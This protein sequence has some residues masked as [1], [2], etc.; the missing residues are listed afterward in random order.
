M[1]QK[2][3][4]FLGILI[5]VAACSPN[6]VKSDKAIDNLFEKAALQ[7]SFALLENGTEQFTIHNLSRYRDSAY[8]PLNS[9]FILPALIGFDKGLINQHPDSWKAFDAA[10]AYTSLIQKIGRQE[11]LKTIDSLHYGKGIVSNNMD[12][13][14]LDNSLVITA[15]EQL[16]LIKKLY[17]NEL[18][19]NKR[20]QDLAKKLIIKEDNANYKLSYILGAANA[21]KNTAWLIGYVEENKHPYFFVLNTEGVATQNVAKQ[22]EQLLK[23]ILLQQGFLKGTR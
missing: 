21:P 10:Q 20:S 22:S 1:L 9:F 3:F 17:F 19:F 11:L 13:F 8:A 18:F 6:N 15:D 14:W 7:G 4:F 5:I 12:S 23:S 16:G 2:S